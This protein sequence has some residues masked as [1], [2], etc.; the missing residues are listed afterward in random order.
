MDH[1]NVDSSEINLNAAILAFSEFGGSARELTAMAAA[2]GDVYAAERMLTRMR[3]SATTF[4]HLLSVE[5]EVAERAVVEL[6][7]Q[8]SR[9][10]LDE[11]VRLINS[12]A[13]SAADILARTGH[14]AAVLPA[15]NVVAVVIPCAAAAQAEVIVPTQKLTA[16]YKNPVKFFDP[17][18]G[19][20][21]S[22]RGP[23]PAW[24]KDL[25]KTGKSLEDF[26]VV[27]AAGAESTVQ[28]EP[29]VASSTPA[30]AVVSEPVAAADTAAPVATDAAAEPAQDAESNDEAKASESLDDVSFDASFDIGNDIGEDRPDTAMSIDDI[31]LGLAAQDESD[32]TAS[33]DASDVSNESSDKPTSASDDLSWFTREF[34]AA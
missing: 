32:S 19:M 8:H 30:V 21:W 10:V 25:L 14:D 16:P 17:A 29:A 31:D 4:S 7:A 15:A 6:K 34:A 3:D 12:G 5:L 33:F 24:L 9:Q 1:F 28:S 20:G 22:G 27:A 2:G 11:V 13:L 18:T 26:R 23:M